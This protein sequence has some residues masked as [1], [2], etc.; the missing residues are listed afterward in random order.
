MKDLAFHVQSTSTVLE[1]IG[2]I[3]QYENS[4]GNRPI[5]SQNVM[6]VANEI[7]ERCTKAFN[8]LQKILDRS[9]QSTLGLVK[10]MMKTPRLKVL[11]L[12]LGEMR[13]NLQCLMQIIYARLKAEPHSTFNESEHRQLIAGLIQQHL[14]AS[15]QYRQGQEDSQQSVQDD[16]EGTS[17]HSNTSVSRYTTTRA[18]QS[19]THAQPTYGESSNPAVV[20][21]QK[22]DPTDF[23]SNST[24]EALPPVGST[25]NTGRG[26]NGSRE[27]AGVSNEP[28]ST[29]IIKT[30][31]RATYY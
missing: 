16:I 10:F 24:H 17:Q 8:E 30:S 26:G 7:G 3:F 15:E 12:G 19:T 9:K 22:P 2:K 1:E 28:T 13:S 29:A 21:M 18:I 27:E 14:A 6:V 5:I 31:Y 23:P 25:P 4:A 11:Q 20:L